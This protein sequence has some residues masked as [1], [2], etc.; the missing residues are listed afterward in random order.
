MPSLI[1]PWIA[2]GDTTVVDSSKKHELGSRAFDENGNEY[3][4]LQGVAST[5]AGM[6]ASF[7][8]AHLTILTVAD[9]VGR[10]AIA[11]AAIVADKYGWYQIYGKHATARTTTAGSAVDQILYLHASPGLVSTVDVAGDAIIGAILRV[12][13]GVGTAAATVELNYPHV[14]NVAID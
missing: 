12:A 13:G 6:W 5:A 11:M 10:I 9:A 3:I 7:D 14:C 2:A 4:Y 8:E 1:G